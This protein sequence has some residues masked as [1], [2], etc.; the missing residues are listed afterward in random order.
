M[1]TLIQ[2]FPFT[3]FYLIALILVSGVVSV[4][5]A[6]AAAD[7]RAGQMMANLFA[8]LQATNHFPNILNIARFAIDTGQPL[9]FSIFIFAGAPSISAIVTSWAGWGRE[10]LARLF[11][12]LK[13]WPHGF[14][15]TSALRCYAALGFGYAAILI[16]Y[17]WVAAQYG[18]PGEF[19]R[20]WG[21]MGG[22]LPMVIFTALSSAFIDEGGTLEEL[23][24]RG[25]AWPIFEDKLRN[26]LLAAVAL[27]FLWAAW[28]LPRELPGLLAQKIPFGAWFS[29]QAIF[30]A[31][32]I[33]ETVVICYAVNR[34]GG[35]IWPAIL[36]HGGTNVWS[37]A[38]GGPMNRLIGTDVRFAI[39]GVAAVAIML[40]AGSQLGRERKT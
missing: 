15:R 33:T 8:W 31:G 26:P 35:S 23:G 18:K 9:A 27:G 38:A 13:P 21:S 16:L 5:L 24:W 25:F 29:G 19:D 3:V 39:L 7:P 32:C 14:P 10:G 30:F 22:S 20:I 2:R 4:R 34:T 12:H 6:M 37:K 40:L 1:Q 17:L 28:H 36:I 11:D